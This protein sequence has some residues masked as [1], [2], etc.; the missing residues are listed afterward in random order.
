[1]SEDFT[2][3]SNNAKYY[4]KRPRH[5]M[6]LAKHAIIDEAE[7]KALLARGAFATLATVH[8]DQ[9][10][11]TPLLY[12]YI[13][14][15]HALYFHTAQVGRTRANVSFEPNAA[16]NVSEFGRIL[17]HWEALEFNVEYNSVTVF[18]EIQ[19]VTEPAAAERALQAL[20]DKYAPHLLPG[21]DYRPIQPEELKRTAVY[22]LAIQ[23]WSAKRQH[24]PD[25]YP[26]AFYYA[27]PPI[28]QR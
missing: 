26:G 13:E 6:R 22:R 27:H 1:M 20:L 3:I 25:D 10:F 14:G 21:R 16:L 7:V 17:P 23:D 4:A 28:I 19:M 18:G 11:L 8:D 5:E 2:E 9:P 12:I 15:D 24:E